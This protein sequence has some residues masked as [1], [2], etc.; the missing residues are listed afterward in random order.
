MRRFDFKMLWQQAT[1]AV[2][3][4]TLLLVAACGE[5]EPKVDPV[6]VEFTNS[7]QTITEDGGAKN[8]TISLSSAAKKDGTLTLSASPANAGTFA[9]FPTEVSVTKGS[10]S[11]QFTLT[12]INNAIIDAGAKVIT[13]TLADATSGFE[14]GE[15]TTLA[16]TITDDEGPTTANF[17]V[18]SGSIVENVGAGIVVG[19]TLSPAAEVAGNIE[20][21]MTPSTAAVT[22]TPAATAG[23]VTVPVAV[24]QTAVSFTVVPVNGTDDSDNFDVAF[25]ITGATGGVIVGTNV[26]Y[27]L[28]VIDDDDLVP[29]DIDDVR[30]LYTTAGGAAQNITTPLQLK[31]I[32]TS[33]NPQVNANN[34][35]VQDATGG[36]VVR[37]VGANTFER[38]DEVIVT[39]TGARFIEFS[40]LLQI[41]NVPNANATLV[42]KN[43]T[44][45]TPEVVT[46]T[47]LKTG[48]YE[49]KLVAVNSVRFVDADGILTMNGTRSITDGTETVNVRTESGASF[50]GSLM[51][52]GSGRVAGLAGV[53]ASVIQIVPIVFADD[54]FANNPVG[55]IGTTS[56][57]TD[58]GSINTG[59]E[60][61]DQS[62]TVQ[63][64]TLTNDIVVT[65]SSGFK[66]SLT[67]GGTYESTVTIPAASANSATTV[68]VKFV[69]VVG[70][71]QSG[72]LSHKSQGAAT[73]SVTVTG[74]G[75]GLNPL[76]ALA[77]W[78]FE[79]LLSSY[80]VTGSS[81]TGLLA[82]SGLQ[83]GAASASGLHA[84]AAT[85]YTSPA[86]NGTARS[87]SSNN[88][89]AGD[90]YQF[91]LNSTGYHDIKISWD[92]T[93]SNTGPGSFVL[94][95]STD[96][97]NF[98]Q[99]GSAYT[100]IN[101]TW[102]AATPKTT[103]S[104]SVDLSSITALNNSATLVFRL[105][106]APGSPSVNGGAIA[107]TGTGRV[108]NVKVEGRQ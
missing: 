59:A 68:Y 86:G 44:L 14:L 29:T 99:F 62:Y 30:A 94:Q 92:Q 63:G 26:D 72:T 78:T 32:V 66:I 75:V 100:V 106:V 8:I 24:G 101:D 53:N 7:A 57:M 39:V 2:F 108:D 38:G 46:L 76:Q 104:F 36:I 43:N 88:W 67:Q 23:K 10:T 105:A 85:A 91:A 87:L 9:T 12:P 17:T 103:T 13:F 3:L 19:I 22:T 77:T 97:T 89:A 47:Q 35:W 42:D 28:T 33:M 98:T 58:F 1:A 81:V 102:S 79:S 18:A 64:T 45:P 61:A 31:G 50:S 90:Y 25:K 84:A 73:V 74:T 15:Q 95:Y 82:E 56:T 34:I 71:A 48:N 55:T 60:S 16:V 96:G 4:L 107:T 27:T 49:G 80:S 37:F 5:D 6:T 21:T 52:L 20:V 70:G 65:A 54:V 11:A 83:S 51:P 93:G 69:P 41:E 40:G